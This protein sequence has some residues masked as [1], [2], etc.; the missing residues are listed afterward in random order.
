MND[1]DK[2][3]VYVVKLHFGFYL[4]ILKNSLQEELQTIFL[5]NNERLLKKICSLLRVSLNGF[6]S[7]TELQMFVNKTFLETFL[8]TGNAY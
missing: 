5:D 4:H 8:L 7:H 1:S 3:T 6:S 2:R